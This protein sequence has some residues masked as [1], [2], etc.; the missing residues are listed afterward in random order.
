MYP[1]FK[2]LFD[3]SLSTFLLIITLPVTLLTGLALAFANGENPFFLQERPGLNEKIFKIIKFKTMNNKKDGDGH[4]LPDKDRL[5]S[6][7]KVVRKL[8]I[9]E[10]PQ[11]INIIKGDMSFVGPRPL[12]VSYLP[13]Y[14]GDEKLRHTVRPGITGLA[15]VSGRNNLTW[16]K[17]MEKDIAYVKNRSFALDFKIFRMTF[18]KV[19][20]QEDIVVDPQSHMVDFIT[21]KTNL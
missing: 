12:L 2:R 10:L 3:V 8:S 14:T 7:G 6:L 16:D 4:L 18:K 13:Y 5:T 17:R 19:I 21:Y 9:D 1:F 20:K 15:Q 11:M